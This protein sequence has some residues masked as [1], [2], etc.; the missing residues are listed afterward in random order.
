MNDQISRGHYGR[1][2][3]GVSGNRLGRPRGSKNRYR[4]RRAD[5]AWAAKWTR[6][7]WTVVYKRTLRETD[8]DAQQKHAAA[9]SECICALVIASPP[10]SPRRTVPSM[11]QASR[12]A[13]EHGQWRSDTGGWRLGPLVM[14]AVVS[15]CAMGCSKSRT[16]SARDRGGFNLTR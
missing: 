5:R 2:L 3:P 10:C 9:F 7:D 6:H 15:P 13:D 12:P 8:G 14:P 16:A 11:Q 1:F 4:R